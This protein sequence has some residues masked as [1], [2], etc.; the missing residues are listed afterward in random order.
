MKIKRFHGKSFKS[1][2]E[3]VKEELGPDAVIL[4]SITKKD[5][6]SNSAVVEITA[7]ID[8]LEEESFKT[9]SPQSDEK[10]IQKE[11][12]KIKLELALLRESVSKLFPSLSDNSKRMLY[13]LMIKIGIEP[14]L[15]I[16]LLEKVSNI[17][18]LRTFIENEIKT[19]E[20]D[21]ENERGF[22]VFGLPGV[23]KTTAINKLAN[24]IREKGQRLMILSLDQRISA[25]ANIKEMAIRLK[26]DGKIIRDA[27]E[28][29]KIVHKEI[30]KSKI[31]ID[32]P[33]DGDLSYAMELRELLKDAP[34]KKCLLIDAS[35]DMVSS[36]R[37][38]KNADISKVDCIAFSKI[39]LSCNY[40][41]LYNL[42][43]YSGKP[44]SFITSGS[45]QDKPKIIPPKNVANLIIG[46]LCEN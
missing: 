14:N 44:L 1:L 9:V 5:P 42:S 31:L 25:V 32:T 23:G 24:I 16:Q 3:K 12:D 11:M 29:Y 10:N 13:S 36:A 26:C 43:V 46:G 28:L 20:R 18:E 40:G 2:L 33:G 27:R 35:M 45:F 19:T 41:N 15:A 22:V 4:S 21:Y 34:I 6:L 30:E 17:N 8:E 37:I 38:I 7:A 39:D